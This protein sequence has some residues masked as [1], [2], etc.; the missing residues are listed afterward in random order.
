[1]IPLVRFLAAHGALLL[2][3]ATVLLAA[4]ALAVRMQRSPL[5]RQRLAELTIGCTLLWLAMAAVP[6]PRLL[7]T[8]P[9]LPSPDSTPDPLPLPRAAPAGEYRP[10]IYLAT[11]PNPPLAAMPEFDDETAAAT[12]VVGR[13]TAVADGTITP[14]AVPAASVPTPRPL[15]PQALDVRGVL[16]TAFVVGSVACGAWLA[17]GACLLGRIVRGGSPPPEWLR[18]QFAG[19]W[20]GRRP[21]ARLLVSGRSRRP[22]S[23]GMFR[24]TILLP[25]GAVD[26]ANASQLRQ[27][28]LHELGHVRQRDAWGNALFNLALPVLYF[29]PLYWLARREAHLARELIADDWAATRS[30]KAQ[31][32]EELVALA[33]STL[34][35]GPTATGSW[36]SLGLF[37]SPSHFYR[38]MHML[39]ERNEP[40]ATSCSRPWRAGTAAAFALGLVVAAGLIGHQPARAQ[41]AGNGDTADTPP[42]ARNERSTAD[43]DVDALNVRLAETERALKDAMKRLEAAQINSDVAKQQHEKR[44]LEIKAHLDKLLAD[45]ELHKRQPGHNNRPSAGGDADASNQATFDDYLKRRLDET[46]LPPGGMS[47]DEFAR[48]VYLDITGN[49]P[50]RAALNAFK[51]D[52]SAEKRARLVQELVRR[53]PQGGADWNRRLG[54]LGTAESAPAAGNVPS[55]N[56]APARDPLAQTVAPPTK[57]DAG[58]IDLVTLA[59]NYIDATGYARTSRAR[60]D[61]ASRLAPNSVSE[62]DMAELKAAADTAE[63]KVKLLRGLIE[64]ALAAAKSEYEY[65]AKLSEKGFVSQSLMGEAKQK[66]Q[67]LELILSSGQ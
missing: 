57:L 19:L 35:R 24:P 11:A 23:C 20:E 16:A 5:H 28:L 1:M 12:L 56:R 66:L 63:R 32:V 55:A 30:G 46:K 33:R 14:A 37:H 50:D 13:S 45:A 42:G 9:P 31:Y 15:R 39:I 54:G 27:V 65:S 22:V 36:T 62:L 52:T 58:Q 6:L 21:P 10:P 60:L 48:R 3:G 8:R 64:I 41:V 40:L 47:D 38:R 2:L 53:H 34:G 26:P 61:A 67:I 7:D 4:G 29:H 25:A 51:A 43:R 49:V 18:E 44:E 59:V 17:L